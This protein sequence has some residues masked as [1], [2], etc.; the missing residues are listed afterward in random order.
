MPNEFKPAENLVDAMNACDTSPLDIDDPRYQDFSCARDFRLEHIVKEFN[1]VLDGNK[2]FHHALCGHRGSGKST[3]IIRL[4][5]RLE[6]ELGVL[7]FYI[8]VNEETDPYD[9]QYSELFLVLAKTLEKQLRNSPYRPEDKILNNVAAWFQEITKIKTEEI[10]MSMGIKTEAS[11]GASIPL[12]GKLMAALNARA[13]AGTNAKKQIRDEIQKYPNALVENMNLLL[14]DVNTKMLK[15]NKHKGIL[16]ILDN[17]DRY[18]PEIVNKLLLEGGDF[19]KELRCHTLITL[20]ITLV[21]QQ[22]GVHPRE[23]FQGC[24]TL[25]MIK[26][27]N[28]EDDIATVSPNALEALKSALS[29]RLV[30][31]KI[32]KHPSLVDELIKASGGSIRDLMHLIKQAC[33]E[34]DEIVDENAVKEAIRRMRIDYARQIGE[35]DYERLARIHL[36]KHAPNDKKHRD[37]IFSRLVLEYVNSETWHDIHPVLHGLSKIQ[38]WIDKLHKH[39]A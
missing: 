31:D 30:I 4:Q 1:S 6:E 8:R 20:P 3:E 5:K 39:K 19:L 18:Q 22:E 25:P 11:I 10:E 34:A 37:L 28:K 26:I 7:V 27:R 17:I 38:E 21:Y 32:F 29:K 33:I 35:K 12:F 36:E 14:D 24:Q 13:S 15:E 23:V 2:Y 9:I 16:F